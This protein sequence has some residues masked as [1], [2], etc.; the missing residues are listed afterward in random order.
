M[1]LLHGALRRARDGP[2]ARR[3]GQ[4]RSCGIQV[5]GGDAAAATAARGVLKRG[6][7]EGKEKKKPNQNCFR[8]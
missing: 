2:L 7:E 8:V 1:L 5:R 6:R 4:V 3:E